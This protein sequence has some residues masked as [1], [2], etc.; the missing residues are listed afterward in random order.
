VAG[1]GAEVGKAC[2]VAVRLDCSVGRHADMQTHVK[3]ETDEA[4]PDE[5]ES[6]ELNASNS[7]MMIAPN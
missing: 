5:A 2:K 4:R 6:S 1:S 3:S 7:A